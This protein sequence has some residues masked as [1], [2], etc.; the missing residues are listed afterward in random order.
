VR[1]LVYSAASDSPHLIQSSAPPYLSSLCTSFAFVTQTD[2]ASR[3]SE[4]AFVSFY[5]LL[6][7]CFVF[8]KIPNGC[9]FALLASIIAGAIFVELCV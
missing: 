9:C 4:A 8:L 6:G 1:L 7:K 2:S 3:V 5:R